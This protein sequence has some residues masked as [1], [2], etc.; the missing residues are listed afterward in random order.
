MTP[1]DND[2]PPPPKSS[3]RG[4]AKKHLT[5][6]EGRCARFLAQRGASFQA[7]ADILGVDYGAVAAA[8]WGRGLPGRP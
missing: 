3:R 7:I 5:R 8:V 6:G 1:Y 2:T 4:K